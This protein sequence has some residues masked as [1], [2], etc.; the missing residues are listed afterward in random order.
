MKN[1]SIVAIHAA[2]ALL[3]VVLGGIATYYS[4]STWIGMAGLLILPLL[5]IG[6]GLFDISNNPPSLGVVT[7]WGERTTQVLKEGIHWL[8]LRGLIFDTINID[9]SKKNIDLGDL[10]IRTPD[11][12]E[13]TAS[14]SYTFRPDASNLLAYLDSKGEEGVK[15]ILNDRI[16]ERAREWALKPDEGP[17]TWM[18][19]AAAQ[20]DAASVLLK[21]VAGESLNSIP[22]G[23]P[24]LLLM[25]YFR[26]TF[27]LD[28]HDADLARFGKER[29]VER[30]E[31]AFTDPKTGTE[32]KRMVNKLEDEK[33]WRNEASKIA[34][35]LIE[36]RMADD[37]Q[38]LYRSDYPDFETYAK[39]LKELVS[40]RAAQIKKIREGRSTVKL[41]S[42]GIFLV[43]LTV[44]NI[45]PVSKK[46]RD[47][48]EE[49]SKEENQR[50]AERLEITHKTGLVREHM[51]ETGCSY[52]EAVDFIGINLNEQHVEKRINTLQ[53]DITPGS[54]EVVRGIGPGLSAAA[55]VFAESMKNKP[56]GKKRQDRKPQIKKK[57][58]E[59]KK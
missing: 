37:Y 26:L 53:L 43:Q 28:Y 2:V 18:E 11:K 23:V 1:T 24:T 57:D 21:A 55:V 39:T 16:Q 25:S 10:I 7:I 14:I 47:T 35:K 33:T 36:E 52:E 15:N 42:L 45:I 29:K 4:D 30:V 12:V 32:K 6:Q 40:D 34:Q 44:K 50:D 5:Y 22:S 31:I 51:E 19:A 3:S 17:R 41:P 27:R 48:A 13:S 49:F 9:V 54:R 8:P 56:V 20:A 58:E 38:K 59:E 46:I